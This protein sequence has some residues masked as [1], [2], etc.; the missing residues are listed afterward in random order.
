MLLSIK[1]L[2]SL[3]RKRSDWRKKTGEAVARKWA[4]GPHKAEEVTNIIKAMALDIGKQPST[5]S[6]RYF[7]TSHSPSDKH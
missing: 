3:A 2:C 4:K 1:N 6:D 7:T 5:Q